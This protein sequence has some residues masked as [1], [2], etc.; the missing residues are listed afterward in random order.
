MIKNLQTIETPEQYNNRMTQEKKNVRL[1]YQNI[2]LKTAKV[3]MGKMN[4][5][6]Y[7][8]TCLDL[9]IVWNKDKDMIF[10]FRGGPKRSMKGWKLVIEEPPLQLLTHLSLGELIL[11]TES[12][13]AKQKLLK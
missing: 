3:V 13:V 5:I 8:V 12:L 2:L 6:A 11:S 7:P 9:T 1:H 4:I 10:F